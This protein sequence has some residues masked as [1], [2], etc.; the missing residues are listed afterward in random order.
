MASRILFD[1][2]VLSGLLG[3]APRAPDHGARLAD[4]ALTAYTGDGPALTHALA[5]LADGLARQPLPARTLLLLHFFTALVRALTKS[6][7]APPLTDLGALRALTQARLVRRFLVLDVAGMASDGLVQV[8]LPAV[9]ALCP[10]T[11]R[12]QR[13][14]VQ[15]AL[16]RHAC[17]LEASELAA[18]LTVLV[19]GGDDAAHSEWLGDVASLALAGAVPA[20]LAALAPRLVARPALL[21]HLVTHN[22][23]LAGRPSLHNAALA[24]PLALALCQH[25]LTPHSSPAAPVELLP[26]LCAWL[27]PPVGLLTRPDLDTLAQHSLLAPLLHAALTPSTV[28][29]LTPALVYVLSAV[30][31]SLWLTPLRSIHTELLAA[32]LGPRRASYRTLIASLTAALPAARTDLAPLLASMSGA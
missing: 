32:P 14:Y 15:A 25:L 19:G 22:A 20:L 10:L 17:A 27:L 12:S 4:A 8:R 26:T 18:L 13:L 28:N 11:P 7:G 23:L 1:E 29:I 6:P 3:D 16:C 24:P 5:R 31:P 9:P 30:P 2:A 21:A